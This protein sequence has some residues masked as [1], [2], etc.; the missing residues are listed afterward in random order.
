MSWSKGWTPCSS[1]GFPNSGVETGF[2]FS[3][4]VDSLCHYRMK[5]ILLSTTSY[6]DT[7]GE[8]HALLDSQG[9]ELVRERG[10]L[11]EER[12]LELAGDLDGALCGDDAFTREVIEKMLPRLK[13]IS[14]YGIGLDKIDLDACNEYKIPV[15]FTPGVNHTTV[16][17]HCFALLLAGVKNLVPS[18]WRSK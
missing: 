1:D 2:C 18:F 8:H 4:I 5:R 15:L 10:P 17:E 16:A 14:K 13:V 9:F 12:M 6:Q 11:A 3:S 7:P